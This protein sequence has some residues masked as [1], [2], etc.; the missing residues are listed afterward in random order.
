MLIRVQLYSFKVCNLKHIIIYLINNFSMRLSHDVFDNQNMIQF[1]CLAVADD[2]SIKTAMLFM[3]NRGLL[4]SWIAL[5][6]R[7]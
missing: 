2:T 4:A 7:H 5:D 6:M 1:T 3:Y